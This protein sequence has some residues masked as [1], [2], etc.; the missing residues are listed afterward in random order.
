MLGIS[1]RDRIRNDEIRA[2]TGVDDVV[3]RILRLKWR[4]AGHVARDYVKWPKAVMQWRPRET[5]RSAGRAQIR[6]HDD[7]MTMVGKSWMRV[8]WKSLEEAY[9]QEWASKG[10][11]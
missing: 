10:L 5:K 6:W 7:V 11:Q 2:R 8:A 9:A 3:T 4:W 1:R